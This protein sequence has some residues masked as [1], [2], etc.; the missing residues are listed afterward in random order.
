[1]TE[2]FTWTP[3]KVQRSD[4]NLLPPE[5]RARFDNYE[6]VGLITFVDKVNPEGT[7]NAGKH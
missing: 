3:V 6:K 2:A 4:Y 1:M 7:G 5:A